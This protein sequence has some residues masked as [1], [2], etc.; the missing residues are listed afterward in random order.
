MTKS[1]KLN[2]IE[3]ITT[4][5][6]CKSCKK[7]LT[8]QESAAYRTVCEDCFT[9]PL[10]PTRKESITTAYSHHKS[11]GYLREKN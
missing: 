9:S 6:L 8:S 1:S 7:K 3:D 5:V 11:R 2:K 4:I 10:H